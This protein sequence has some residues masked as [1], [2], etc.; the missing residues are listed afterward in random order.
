MEVVSLLPMKHAR[1]QH[2]G[3]VLERDIYVAG[4][5]SKKAVLNF[6]EK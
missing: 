1:S 4:G 3:A 5:R 2:A 6:V